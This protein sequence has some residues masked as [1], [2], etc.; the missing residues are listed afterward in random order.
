MGMN[1]DLS[2]VKV[3]DLDPR[4]HNFQRFGREIQNSAIMIGAAWA[5]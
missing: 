4:T 1:A 3:N 5:S 2:L